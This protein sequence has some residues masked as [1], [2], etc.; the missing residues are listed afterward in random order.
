MNSGSRVSEQVVSQLLTEMSGIEDMEGVVVIAATN[1][2]D[3]IDPALL[4][5]GRFDSMVYVPAPDQKTRLEILKTHMKE[6]PVKGLDMEALAEKTEGYSGADLEAVCR[7]AGLN[8]LRTDMNANEI[9]KKDFNDALNKIKPSITQDMFAKYQKAVED[10][11]KAKVE[12]AEKSR[13]IG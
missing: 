13:Y 6:M 5:P 11:K 9:V 1:R 4:R 8:A 10:V 12:E 3:I 2:P 7:E